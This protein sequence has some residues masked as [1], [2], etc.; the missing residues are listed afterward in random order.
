VGC[1]GTAECPFLAMIGITKQAGIV[2]VLGKKD[3]SSLG[4]D[5]RITWYYFGSNMKLE[6]QI[7]L[8]VKKKNI[9]YLEISSNDDRFSR[10]NSCNYL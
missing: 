10:I 6:I 4:M 2:T 8:G 3:T 5:P 7:L 1:S 9:Y